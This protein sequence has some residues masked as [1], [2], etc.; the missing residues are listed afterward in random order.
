MDFE[1]GATIILQTLFVKS[2]NAKTSF[3]F[4][5]EW[6][7]FILKDDFCPWTVKKE[8]AIDTIQDPLEF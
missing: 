1:A 6:C 3:I 7:P 8:L 4:F 5:R 2:L